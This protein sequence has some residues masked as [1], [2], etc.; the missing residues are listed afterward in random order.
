MND[1]KRD[2]HAD[3][4]AYEEAFKKE[5][6]DA[7][8]K[9]PVNTY[10]T[11]SGMAAFTTILNFLVMEKKTEGTILAGSAM[12]FENKLLL[13]A[14]F[15]N[16]LLFV[17]ESDTQ[18]VLDA[19]TAHQPSAIF[20]DSLCNSPDVQVPDLPSITKYLVRTVKKETYLIIDN[21]GLSFF[22]QPIAAVFGKNRKLHCLAFESLNKYHQFGMDRVTGGIISAV[23]KGTGNLYL[24][25]DN[26]GTNIP[27]TSVLSLPRPNRA[28]LASRM[29]RH[30]RNTHIL[31]HAIEKWIGAYP[32]SPLEGVQYPGLG[33]HSSHIYARSLPFHG[34]FFTLSF[35]RRYRTIPF[36]KKLKKK[37]LS[38]A[39]KRH[40][41]I[42]AG[43]SFG[44]PVT[45]IYLT[46]SNT[47]AGTPFLRV[48]VGTEHRCGIAAVAEVFCEA[49]SA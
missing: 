21:T 5:Y 8:L 30:A 33:L 35:K 48:A 31:A 47:D 27:D 23:G 18:A 10:A 44:L 3:A 39:R 38:V 16:R 34:S 40:V 4:K 22:Y 24:Y 17:D 11:V 7:P 43:T 6:I 42:A 32:D 14:M 20:L 46:A 25:R 49:I 9:F 1:Y 36:Y 45:R 37:L 19:I 15:S 29:M 2:Q 13:E 28:L 41:D 12:Y 26:L